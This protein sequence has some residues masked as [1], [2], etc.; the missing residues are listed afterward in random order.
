MLDQLKAQLQEAIQKS[1]AANQALEALPEFQSLTKYRSAVNELEQQIKI[2]E[3]R[4]AVEQA[5]QTKQEI[6]A[7]GFEIRSGHSTGSTNHRD[8]QSDDGE[9][10][11]FLIVHSSRP[12]I[13][14]VSESSRGESYTDVN[15][16]DFDENW[17]L[18]HGETEK[19]VWEDAID[20]WQDDDLK[21]K[22]LEG[23]D[24]SAK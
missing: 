6:L 10:W 7:A 23:L 3:E 18:G 24:L 9:P 8:W 2:E 17:V 20:S 15:N 12:H 1:V 16:N 14:H 13:A 22:A 5:E 21:T 4:I 11:T 19:E